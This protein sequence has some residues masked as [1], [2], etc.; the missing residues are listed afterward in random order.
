MIGSRTIKCLVALLI[1]AT[2]LF[3]FNLMLSSVPR[4]HVMAA[5]H[6]EPA[7]ALA[8]SPTE[9]PQTTVYLPLV[10]RNCGF[11]YCTPQMPMW[12]SNDGGVLL[13]WY[14]PP[15]CAQ[16]V[17]FRITRTPEGGAPSVVAKGLRPT[18][19]PQA[20]DKLL[21]SG[22]D[23]AHYEATMGLGTLPELLALRTLNPMQA[24]YLANNVPG[25]A[26]VYAW[27]YSDTTALHGT[28]Y[29]YHIAAV[30]PSDGKTVAVGEIV[31][32]VEKTTP[33]PVPIGLAVTQVISED[34]VGDLDWA[35]A[36]KNR[37]ADRDIYL[38][39]N[40]STTATQAIVAPGITPPLLVGYDVYRG[41]TPNGPFDTINEDPVVPMAA[42]PASGDPLSETYELHD[43]YICDEDPTL[44]YSQT[45][46]YRVAPRDLL[47]QPLNWADSAH[48]ARFSEP[49]E[50][51]PRDT[52]PP[53][54]PLDLT[55]S[56]RHLAGTIVL[57]WTPQLTDTVGYELSWSRY[58]TASI[59]EKSPSDPER[60]WMPL[61]ALDDPTTDVFTHTSPIPLVEDVPY[62]YRIRAIDAFGNLS[63]PS[64]PVF[65]TLHDRI[66]PDAPP[67]IYDDRGLI[68]G[69]PD[70]VT[71]VYVYCAIDGGP[72]RL[73]R[74]L[75]PT[76]EGG[77]IYDIA[78][79]YTPP[80]RSQFVCNAQ[81]VDA[82]GNRSGFSAN[83]GF[84][85]GPYPTADPPAPIIT[86]ITTLE[87]G[88][89]DWTA[90]LQWTAEPA[91]GVTGYRIYRQRYGSDDPPLL[92]LDEDTV[93]ES[94]RIAFDKTV[95]PGI[96]YSYT[97]AAYRPAGI[98]GPDVET[99]ST[100][101]LYKV[102]P[103]L[104][105]CS[106]PLGL[107]TW[108]DKTTYTP[109]IG[110][111][112]LWEVTP[113]S[114]YVR[115]IVFRSPAAGSGFTQ[116][117]PPLG[118]PQYVDTDAEH[119]RYV[120]V[121][122]QLD[123]ATGE[124]IRVSPPWSASGSGA[125]SVARSDPA[126]ITRLLAP[127]L[128]AAELN[129]ITKPGTAAESTQATS[130]PEG[131][132]VAEMQPASTDG[133]E[134]LTLVAS[135]DAY[136]DTAHDTT[137]YG[138]EP[139]MLVGL[140]RSERQS[141]LV[142]FD[143]SALPDDSIIHEAK[144][145]AHVDKWSG[146]SA[147]DIDAAQ[148]AGTWGELKVTALHSPVAGPVQDTQS[149]GSS[150]GW[151]TWTV[152]S[153]V[154]D[155]WDGT[156]INYGIYLM[157]PHTAYSYQRA[158][159]TRDGS[160]TQAPSL[161]ISYTV[162]PSTLFF[163]D[164]FTIDVTE[165]DSSS[166]LK[167]L[168]G[169]G[170][171]TLGGDPL[172]LITYTVPFT[173]VEATEGGTV[174]DGTV[175]VP[176][177]DP[178]EISYPG[179][180]DYDISAIRVTEVAGGAQISLT[181][182]TDIVVHVG[183]QPF[184]PFPWPVRLH[185]DLTFDYS[186]DAGSLVNQ[187][188]SVV[189][190]TFYFEMN[191]LPLR[192]VPTSTVTFNELAVSFPGGCTQY[193]ERFTGARPTP[194]DP[195]AGD[196]YLR[197]AYRSTT[198]VTIDT[199]GLDGS[200]ETDDG[201]D[202]VSAT[203]YGF[204]IE[205]DGGEFELSNSRIGSGYLGEGMLRFRYYQT[206]LTET[207]MIPPPYP[208]GLHESRFDRLKLGLDGS[209]TGVVTTPKAI[210][211]GGGAFMVDDGNYKLFLPPISTS[212]SPWSQLWGDHP[213]DALLQ[214]G[215]NRVTAPEESANFSWRNCGEGDPVTFPDGVSTDLYVRRG[216]VSDYV[217][218]TI[219]LE[220]GIS[221]GFY[222]YEAELTSFRVVF[223][224]NSIHNSDVAANVMLPYPVD[225]T[226]PLIHMA[227]DADTGCVL[228][229]CVS[230]E[231]DP[232]T[233]SYWQVDLHPDAVEFREDPDLPPPG[234]PEHTRKLWLLGTMDVP[235]LSPP[236]EEGGPPIG[237]GQ[238][239]IP[240]ET[241]FA[242]DGTFYSSKL[243]HQQAHYGF[244]GFDAMVEAISLSSYAS[245]EQPTWETD[246]TLGEPPCENGSCTQGFVKLDV[247]LLSPLFGGLKRGDNRPQLQLVPDSDYVGFTV[248]P[249][250]QRGW[251]AK[252][253]LGFDFELIYAHSAHTHTAR[254]IAWDQETFLNGDS[255]GFDA[256]GEY[257]KLFQ[258]DW[259]TI[260]SPTETGVYFGLSTAP[261][262]VRSLAEMTIS[263][264]VPTSFT[265][266]LSQTAKNTWFPALGISETLGVTGTQGYLDLTGAIW[267]NR[268]FDRPEGVSEALDD[269]ITDTV[270]ITN[271]VGGGTMG[272]LKDWG[273][274]F[275]EIR[276]QAAF[277]PVYNGNHDLVDWDLEEL[278]VSLQFTISWGISKTNSSAVQLAG[279]PS[280]LAAPV[281]TDR[282][283][284]AYAPELDIGS[285]AQSQAESRYLDQL[286]M[287]HASDSLAVNQI[288][289]S[290]GT[291]GEEKKD[292]GSYIRAKRLTFRIT[293]DGDYILVG[294][295]VRTTLTED[296]KDIDFALLLNVKDDP[297]LEGGLVLYEFTIKGIKFKR[298]GAVFGVGELGNEDFGY[299][300]DP[301]FYI[302]AL[303]DAK[304]GPTGDEYTAG[305]A[306]LIGT[307]YTQSI[308]LREMGFAELL[309]TLNT[310]SPD[311]LIGGYVRVYGDFPVYNTGCMYNLTASGEAA[312]WYF[313][314]RR[315]DDQAWG[316]RI[317]GYVHGKVLC[318]VS[319]RGDLTLEIRNSTY[320]TS[321]HDYAFIGQF[322]VA[323][324]IGWCSPGSWKKWESKW[325][326]D[327]WCYCCGAMI[328]CDYN[329]TK[330]DDWKWTTDAACE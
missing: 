90:V 8:T 126:A 200:F 109:G 116:L 246:A 271:P 231:G 296:V 153:L 80:L 263:P 264:T 204:C 125:Q 61:A 279:G 298:V 99:P 183:G 56:A 73:W 173:C 161:V 52:A 169:H 82:N 283:P 273:V 259:A 329:V 327:K 91:P 85:L 158:F 100:Y 46:F 26:L 278:H 326:G 299:P 160:H 253:G 7:S 184:D 133:E 306:I 84:E 187:D 201:I 319:A 151:V 226:V 76:M 266:E 29:T 28:V 313:A 110:A 268:Y 115:F 277:S 33:L 193:D 280:A 164:G 140:I 241:S 288:G 55:A 243:V 142:A 87:G 42:Q 248:Q 20:A 180:L 72:F 284:C 14:W 267:K 35:A 317:R 176:I 247:L 311:V 128:A 3:S 255:F 86:D 131:R 43:Y 216:G 143:L 291:A 5:E 275:S 104:D 39:W 197:P 215:L 165:Y 205:A 124:L 227:L 149:V 79:D 118:G 138:S 230:D 30:R 211:W 257:L 287:G 260:I 67:M 289:R 168:T 258:M 274:D 232:L 141:S 179:G 208:T 251:T 146:L 206:L 41:T 222:G 107:I 295:K 19:D 1:A 69:T 281:A 224:D 325:W 203:P 134:Q 94:D 25:V 219:P 95:E 62:W 22:W 328:Q 123:W 88:T 157:G 234:Q 294:K 300:G 163:G 223:C 38:R 221:T 18:T 194:P 167:C 92:A 4:Q 108:R 265:A 49:V 202:Y 321:T 195:D 10:F 286:L 98:Y 254:F 93:S 318:V 89:Y 198:A 64:E 2:L 242:P 305:G 60:H 262:L 96:V 323:G 102:I 23:W 236:R 171:M 45:Y 210:Q 127:A 233:L 105:C 40:A 59:L 155:W 309:D 16:N 15:A 139:Q 132:A 65:A 250:V 34:H 261:A 282:T 121:V 66:P 154:Q 135:K 238:E 293:R 36:Q 147:V 307:I 188:C 6:R 106:R 71:E 181:L 220:E 240:I 320:T 191:P 269:Y 145:A 252:A 162:P 27:G 159:T 57:T 51:I 285:M 237:A 17:E 114:D 54:V 53:P 97:V 148:I 78:G 192:V 21:G 207:L 302:G 58:P 119:D 37:K 322:W 9:P 196:G 292:E 137:N 112:L 156:R 199:H 303:G 229:G 31:V 297:R 68:I 70:D 44:V 228:G 185:P 129:D 218:A 111:N 178:I 11:P 312:A 74:V 170:T 75:T 174:V 152:T 235:H 214:P 256:A 101:R 324:G 103:P 12:A 24:R 310:V 182:P 239:P 83:V 190:P 136:I 47:G 13:R 81:A 50:A 212:Q 117:T 209:V 314:Q 308:V 225:A 175:N 172:D 304:F 276:G 177:D 272:K 77:I 150:I 186:L 32:Q 130:F 217:S 290:G 63:A 315:G 213:Q 122:V 120:Y 244:D 166:T 316:G 270:E 245:G 249:R 144:L 189:T 48:R 330:V 113:S 301:F